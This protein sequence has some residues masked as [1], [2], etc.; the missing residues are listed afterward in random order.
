VPPLGVKLIE[1]F[2]PPLQETFVAETEAPRP[3]V[4]VT[5]NE[6]VEELPEGSVAVAVTV[7]VPKEKVDPEAVE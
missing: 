4:T 1:P 3:F 6:Q 5:V 2:D 7:V